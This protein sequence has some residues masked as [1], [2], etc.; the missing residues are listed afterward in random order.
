M[1]GKYK[2]GFGHRI[3]ELDYLRGFA[4]LGIVLVNILP[5]LELGMPK[6]GSLDAA[7][8][9]LLYLFVEGRFYTIFT[10]LFG[11]GFY[12]FI[13]RANEKGK[14]GVVLFLRRI[15][16]LFLFGLVHVQF[17]PGEALTVYAVC[18]LLLLPFYKVNKVMNLF[19]GLVMFIIF[20]MFSFKLFMVIPIMLLGITAGQFRLFEKLSEKKKGIAV[21][22]GIM[23]VL[24]ISGLLYQYQHAPFI[25]EER[26]EME[27][28]SSQEF[29]RI[30]III[31][32]IV[33]AFYVGLLVLLLQ[34][35]FI[36]K[37]L[38]PLKSYGRM[39]LTNYMMQT[40]II[41]VA[42]NGFH[43][44]G[45]ISLIHSFFICLMIYVIQ[46]SFS[47]IWLRYFYYGPLEWTWRA[48]TYLQIPPL[49]NQ[50]GDRL[51]GD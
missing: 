51:S 32:P 7:Y 41:L 38:S 2:M 24:S 19:L 28:R 33:S 6:A 26:L 49:L 22:T 10:F 39:A 29:V 50:M 9:R 23:F 37:L 30:G 12:I 34:Y 21:F 3:E 36:Q 13:T 14:N 42:G 40:V 11:V 17:H 5:L 25:I 31:G 27:I 47:V 16:A 4:L 43:L 8:W 1:K 18:G 20:S 35:R 48:I 46:L 15:V 44:I 45:N